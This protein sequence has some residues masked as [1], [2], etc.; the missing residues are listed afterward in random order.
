[1]N[2]EKYIKKKYDELNILRVTLDEIGFQV[3]KEPF[4]NN[5]IIERIIE[6]SGS[7]IFNFEIEGL[8]MKLKQTKL[9]FNSNMINYQIKNPSVYVMKSFNFMQKDFIQFILISILKLINENKWDKF[10]IINRTYFIVTNYYKKNKDIL[11]K[12]IEKIYDCVLKMNEEINNNILH[13]G[14]VYKYLINFAIEKRMTYNLPFYYW[15]EK[16]ND[17]FNLFF[18]RINGENLFD[19]ISKN[20]NIDDDFWRNVIF[21]IIYTLNCF[22]ILGINYTDY[23][24]IIVDING[25]IKYYLDK[26]NYFLIDLSKSGF[27]K[28]IDTDFYT[29]NLSKLFKINNC[30]KSCDFFSTLYNLN[31]YKQLFFKEQPT[32]SF[33]KK[34]INI[35]NEGDNINYTNL[36]LDEY[37]KP[38]YNLN[39]DTKVEC[40]F[41]NL[42]S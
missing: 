24:V 27:V 7:D 28:I 41:T 9:G 42:Y 11:M 39:S 29:D 8:Q 1:M 4:K 38:L 33:I 3:H 32:Y 20:K 22:D 40:N 14:Y 23:N 21:Q 26:I 25:E 36:L 6:V 35:I 12:I 37:F 13:E 16:C 15:S 5:L 31:K 18:E 34:Y 19:I 30:E 2:I 10:N 17:N